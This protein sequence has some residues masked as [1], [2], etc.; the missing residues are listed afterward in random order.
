MPTERSAEDDAPLYGSPR[1]IPEAT[2][3][4]LPVYQRTLEELLRAGVTTV[5][6]ELL[7][8]AARVNAAK[9][10]RD[11]SLLGSFGTRGAGYDTAFLIKQIDHRLGLDQVWPVVIAGV[12]NLGRALARSQGFAAR[13]FDV[14]G[15]IDSD[16]HIVGL[17]VDGI[18]VRPPEDLPDIMAEAHPAIGVITVPAGAAQH[19]ADLLVG[20]GVRSLLNF[21]PQVLDVAADVL[22][23]YVDLSIEL[24]ILSFF[25]AQRQTAS[26]EPAEPMP[27]LGSSGRTPR[28][29]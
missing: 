13:N 7:A 6:S 14:V 16:P 17:V 8:S 11:L 5:S 1:R 21:A 10:R 25:E 24:Q 23:R 26:D 3:A 12:G 19:V 20:A 9:V 27:V 4:R 2:V 22:I 29:G 15:L 18:R 28:V